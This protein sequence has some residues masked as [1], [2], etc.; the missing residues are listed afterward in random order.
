MKTKYQATLIGLTYT[1]VCLLSY[2]TFVVPMVCFLPIALPVEVFFQ[3]IFK[4]QGYFKIGNSMIL[5]FLGIFLFVSIIFFRKF[6]KQ[7]KTTDTFNNTQFLAFLTLQLFIIHPLIFYIILS[8]NPSR[9]SEGLFI[10]SVDK[11]FQLSS[12]AFVIF[13]IALDA[14]KLRLTKK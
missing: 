9:D 7:I 8:K 13:G 14:L 11:T 4:D 5:T 3:N 1:I 12:I 2:Y 6:I 10:L